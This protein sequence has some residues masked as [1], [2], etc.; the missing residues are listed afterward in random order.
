MTTTMTD[1]AAIEGVTEAFNAAAVE[2]IS[3]GEPEWLREQRQRAWELYEQTPMPTTRL[4]EW[5]YT[6]LKRQLELES[7]AW[8]D[9]VECED[10]FG[11]CPEGLQTAMRADHALSLIHISEPTR[12]ILVS[13]MPSSA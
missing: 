8:P 12:P 1:T 5:R 10:D 3:L 6:N 11:A 13:R 2:R 7:L 4:E 9:L